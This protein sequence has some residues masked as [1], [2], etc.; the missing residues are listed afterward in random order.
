MISQSMWVRIQVQLNRVLS[1]SFFHRRNQGVGCIHLRVQLGQDPPPVSPGRVG[2]CSPVALAGWS[3]PAKQTCEKRQRGKEREP[4]RRKVSYKQPDSRA[5]AQLLWLLN[6]HW[7]LVASSDP[8]AGLGGHTSVNM[9]LGP[10]KGYSSHW[11]LA[12]III[13]ETLLPRLC[14][15]LVVCFIS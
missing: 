9:V 8:R 11:V 10:F 3:F 4:S 5:G 7:K 14:T 15:F 13:C 6:T 2:G 1:F 12:F